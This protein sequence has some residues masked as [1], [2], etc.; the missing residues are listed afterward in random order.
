MIATR[1]LVFGVCFLFVATQV[2]GL[3]TPSPAKLTTPI[4]PN[5]NNNNSHKS[6]STSESTVVLLYNKPA[7]VV[8]SHVHSE[9]ARPT[10]Y[11]EIQSMKGFV[12]S[13][14][15]LSFQEATGIQSKLHAIGRLDAETTG[16]LLLTND[17][18]LV[19]HVTNPSAKHDDNQQKTT[20][21]VITK[22]YQAWIMG[23]Q[24]EETL[25]QV[26]QGVDIG[27]KYGGMTKPVHDLQ[28]LERPNHKST[29]VSLTISE[30]KNRQVRRMF[31]AIGS[32]VMKLHR[33]AIGQDLTLDGV[34]E[35]EWRILSSEEVRHAL[36]YEPRELIADNQ[37][38]TPQK[39]RRQPPSGRSNHNPANGSGGGRQRR[40]RR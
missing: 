32:G 30:G 14:E 28:I 25:E 6:T 33:T 5:N 22:T 16:L 8:T 2:R 19:H 13:K 24:T 1:A 17:G 15:E 36:F 11:D 37:Q 31:H 27:A 38:Q 7:N 26:R 29:V 18:R 34:Q 12:A 21:K 23:H 20:P 3:T 4:R 39:Q 10:V 9:D 40:K 35:G